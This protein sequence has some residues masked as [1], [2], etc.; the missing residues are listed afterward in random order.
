MDA[1]LE[2]SHLPTRLATGAF[3]LQSG[4]TKRHLD[5][6]GAKHLHGMASEAYPVFQG[7][8]P[9][10][11]AKALSATEIALGSILLVP[12]VP[13]WMAGSALTAFSGGLLGLYLRLPG[14]RCDG[15]LLPTSDGIPLAKDVWM[16]A[17]GVSLLVA[18]ATDGLRRKARS[19]RSP[20]RRA[21]D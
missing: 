11:F 7:L 14:M 4:L 6:E 2:L 12:V 3:L 10:L 9:E 1:V 8:D 21:G 5:S 13:K 18:G 15:G 20:L 19:I 17:I 16:A